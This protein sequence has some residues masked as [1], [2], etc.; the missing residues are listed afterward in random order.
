MC[1]NIYF[2]RDIKAFT[3]VKIHVEV[4]CVVTPCGVPVGYRRFGGPC[5]FHLEG[6]EM[7]AAWT[8]ETLVSYRNTTRPQVEE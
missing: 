5:C 7:M 8:S 1:T 4:F 3:A 6:E 2:V